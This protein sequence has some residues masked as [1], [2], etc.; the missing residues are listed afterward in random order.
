MKQSAPPAGQRCVVLHADDFGMNEAVTQGILRGF[1]HGLL[2][3]TSVLANGPDL[4]AALASYRSLFAESQRHRIPSADRRR[5]LGDTLA[6]FDL[7]VHL[8]LTQ[9]RP[10]TGSRYPQELLNRSGRF[11]GVWSL[12]A[13]LMRHPGQFRAAIADELSAQ[14]DAVRCV[15][16]E[17]THL[18]GHQYVELLPDVSEVLPLLLAKYEIPTVRI[19]REERLWRN[20]LVSGWGLFPFRWALAHL[21]R[22]FACRFAKQIQKTRTLGPRRFFGTMHAGRVNSRIMRCFLEGA[23]ADGITEIGLHPAQ[24][25][26]HASRL[27]PDGWQDPISKHRVEELALLTSEEF[28]HLLAAQGIV[29]GRLRDLARHPSQAA[30]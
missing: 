6:P 15:G 26:N 4:H 30:A 13:R 25:P 24:I 7:G 9:G 16:L 23:A 3:S 20:V 29:L 1:S 18:N 2:T 28:A 17:L 11:P 12:A 21:K 19:A 22:Q 10:L 27:A 14:I 5:R 8:N